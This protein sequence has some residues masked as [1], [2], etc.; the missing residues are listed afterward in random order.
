MKLIIEDFK[1]RKLSLLSRRARKTNGNRYVT[2]K[3]VAAVVRGTAKHVLGGSDHVKRN[4]WPSKAT[5]TR[6]KIG[7]HIFIGQN[8][9]TLRFWAVGLDAL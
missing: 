3:S 6:V 5:K 9:R 8:A 7:C 4:R 1:G 2:R